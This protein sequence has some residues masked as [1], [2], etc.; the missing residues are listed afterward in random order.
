MANKG[1]YYNLVMRQTE[2]REDQSGLEPILENGETE[3]MLNKASFKRPV[4]RKLSRQM[5]RQFSAHTEK[6]EDQEDDDEDIPKPGL[7][8]L[9]KEN[10]PEQHDGVSTG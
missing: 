7:F 8:R 1:L 6:K 9:L 5:S 3:P 10:S 4:S 2:G